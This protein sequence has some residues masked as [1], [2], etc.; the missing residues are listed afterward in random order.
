MCP[1]GLHYYC[2]L[3]S[4]MQVYFYF[5]N[6][7]GFCLFAFFSAKVSRI[8]YVG[9]NGK[10]YGI[11]LYCI[12]KKWFTL[13]IKQ[14]SRT[15]IKCAQYLLYNKHHY[16][17]AAVSGM[18]RIQADTVIHSLTR[19]HHNNMFYC[20]AYACLKCELFNQ[21]NSLGHIAS[22]LFRCLVPIKNQWQL[23]INTFFQII[24]GTYMHHQVPK[25]LEDLIQNLH[26]NCYNP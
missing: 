11:M 6:F 4:H 8:Q 13:T 3:E 20:L 21:I 25:Y 16:W 12:L 5:W 23:G 7:R 24:S 9:W 22:K 26:A 18:V 14:S 19:L 10:V 15:Q 1:L 2:C 17:N